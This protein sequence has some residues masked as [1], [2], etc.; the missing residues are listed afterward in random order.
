MSNEEVLHRVKE[1]INIIQTIKRRKANWI[2][3]ILH[4]N[5]FLKHIIGGKIEGMIDMRGR[6]GRRRKELLYDL[7]EKRG[8]WKLKEVTL[9]HT[10]WGTRFGKDYGPVI[11]QT[12]KRT[13]LCQS[14]N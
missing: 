2:G 12:T 7:K 5:C 1:E 13:N 4:R 9:H 8:Y 6:Q 3:H 11:R 10:L 14:S